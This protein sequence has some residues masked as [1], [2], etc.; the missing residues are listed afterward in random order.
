[1]MRYHVV[2][3]GRLKDFSKQVQCLQYFCHQFCGAMAV[4]ETIVLCNETALIPM[5]AACCFTK[6]VTFL[7]DSSNQ[8]ET[9]LEQLT[10]MA[11][12][13][14]CYLF[15]YQST[16]TEIAVRLSVR[17]NGSSIL[18]GMDMRVQDDH[19]LVNRMLYS[20]HIK[21]EFLLT[22]GPYCISI[23]KGLGELPVEVMEHSIHMVSMEEQGATYLISSELI[24]EEKIKTLEDAKILVIAG[25]GIKD[26][27]ELEVLQQLA[28]R[29]EG[30]LGV[31]RPVAMN[32]LAPMHW[33]VGVSGA[34][35]KPKLCIAV[36]VSGASALYAGIEKSRYI[37]AINTDEKAPLVHKA[38]LTLIGDGMDVIKALLE[39]LEKQQGEGQV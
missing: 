18:S 23:A 31:S 27:Q 37:I 12:K 32:A 39:I 17:T 14:D 21:G 24:P 33:M 9:I 29:L 28:G 2:L 1:M 22:K 15:G 13:E 7:I 11:G 38:D 34:M 5:L 35:T 19:I 20:N 3:D 4:G 16:L 30:E 25:R 26:K 8:V 6:K 36:G 10:S